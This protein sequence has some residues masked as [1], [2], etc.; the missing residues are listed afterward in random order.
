MASSPC[1]NSNFDSGLEIKTRSVEQTLIPLVSQVSGMETSCHVAAVCVSVCVCVCVCGLGH[2]SAISAQTTGSTTPAMFG[3]A[4]PT[5]EARVLAARTRMFPPDAVCGP[6]R[7]RSATDFF[8]TPLRAF[9]FAVCSANPSELRAAN[10][11]RVNQQ[12]TL[13]VY[14]FPARR[15]LHNRPPSL[16]ILGGG[17]GGE[18]QLHFGEKNPDGR[19]V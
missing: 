4:S 8:F 2:L 6:L 9:V 19:G 10:F 5:L 1:G 11:K 13:Q 17:W 3:N 14:L 16:Q 12:R 15:T 7:R 18:L